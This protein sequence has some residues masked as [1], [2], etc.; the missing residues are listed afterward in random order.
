MTDSIIVTNNNLSFLYCEQS[1][2]S[3]NFSEKENRTTARSLLGFQSIQ[4]LNVTRLVASGS[5]LRLCVIV[6]NISHVCFRL[7]DCLVLVRGSFQAS[8]LGISVMTG[9]VTFYLTMQW[10]LSSSLCYTEFGTGYLFIL[11]EHGIAC[12]W[13][14]MF[15]THN[16]R[17]KSSVVAARYSLYT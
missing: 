6:W 8:I 5:R 11:W 1:L 13:L 3:P 12:S 16:V 9:S 7:L 14:Q 15:A 2:S 10:A 17:V 4:F